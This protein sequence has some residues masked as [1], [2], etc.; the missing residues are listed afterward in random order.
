MRKRVVYWTYRVAFT[1]FSVWFKRPPFFFLF[2]FTKL[3]KNT[4]HK[5]ENENVSDTHSR[6]NAG[7]Y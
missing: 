3:G 4:K 1:L 2:S 6:Q 5:G 7:K